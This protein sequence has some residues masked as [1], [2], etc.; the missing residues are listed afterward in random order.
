[1]ARSDSKCLV[2]ARR[3]SP[4]Q[5]AI[6]AAL[7]GNHGIAMWLLETDRDGAI[8]RIGSWDSGAVDFSDAS[9]RAGRDEWGNA[10]TPSACGEVNLADSFGDGLA[11]LL[12]AGPTLS[13]RAMHLGIVCAESSCDLVLSLIRQISMQTAMERQFESAEDQLAE[14]LRA[15]D[16]LV[17]QVTEDFEELTFLRSISE[18][19]E[20]SDE[21]VDY[22]QMAKVMMEPLTRGVRAQCLAFVSLDESGNLRTDLVHGDSVLQPNGFARLIEALKDSVE[23][24]PFV[25][26]RFSQS[27][28]GSAFPEIERLLIVK[29]ASSRRTL[30]YLVA[31]NRTSLGLDEIEA[32]LSD[33]SHMEFGTAEAALLGSAGSILAAHAHNVTLLRQKESL[34]TSVIRA[35]VSAIEAKDQ[36]TRGHSDRVALYGQVLARELGL[37]D[38]YVEK[39]YLSGLLHD[40]GKIGV[41]DATLRKPGKLTDEEFE[42]IKKHPD[43][44][45]AILQDIEQLRDILPGVL[46]HHERIDGCG[47]PDGLH[48]HNI[49]LDGRLLAVAD[50]WDAMTS[51]RPYRKGM[52]DEKAEAILRKGAGTQWDAQIVDAFF[53]ARDEIR[54]V[55]NEYDMPSKPS[56]ESGSP[57]AGS[58]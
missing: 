30:G 9:D 6:I 22:L 32:R 18:Y 2:I 23:G 11:R 48:G 29:M 37:L 17:V 35:M 24:R 41:S 14:L 20:C 26:N 46:Y 5:A 42:E 47:Y 36:Y 15:N 25:Q 39:I 8:C 4:E 16:S 54:R 34:L 45:W 55:A 1:V 3:P 28:L 49:P 13:E 7:N 58:S 10:I 51:D 12:I 21:T 38:S 19:L 56:R 53:R 33:L 44:G 40:V 50:A 52:P 43:E 57:G 27:V 31:V